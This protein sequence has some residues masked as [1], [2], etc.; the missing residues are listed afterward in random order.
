M[1][2]TDGLSVPLVFLIGFAA[3]RASLCT[4]RAVMQWLDDH[5]ASVL[6]SFIKA[7]AWSC[8]LA[9]VFVLFGLPIK[10]VPVTHGVWWL[11]ILGGFLF[12]MGAAINGG[13]SLS[14]VQQLADGD[15]TVLLTLIAFVSGVAGTMT[16]E[17][18]WLPQVVQP[19]A[20]W[21][22]QLTLWQHVTLVTVLMLWAVRKLVMQW[23][24]RDQSLSVLQRFVAPRYRLAFGALLLG[25]AS[26]LLF[27]LEGT[28]TYTNYLREQTKSWF[29]D[30][31]STG[32][33]R[34]ILVL[35]LFVGMLTS[36]F[37]RGSFS[38]RW[39]NMNNWQRRVL[40]GLLM[41][42]GGALVP[43][44]NDTLILVLIPTLSLQA[45][46][47]YVALLAGIGSVLMV[48]RSVRSVRT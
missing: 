3:H 33:L 41:G 25:V 47:S 24:R 46:A 44:G 22:Q 31:I 40:G 12:G 17:N 27:L 38:W 10:G 8:L 35:T 4:V 37:H 30:G 7:A 13:C 26:G 42:S 48:M 43:G 16:L 36:S 6:I 2:L 23:Q 32:W 28:W 11:G 29:F 19:Q 20:L 21:W 45:L 5:K 18:L 1:T 14:T 9:G 39:P 34:G 15:S